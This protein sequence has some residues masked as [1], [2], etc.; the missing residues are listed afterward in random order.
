M[1]LSDREIRAALARGALRLNPIPSPAAWSSTAVDLTLNGPLSCWRTPAGKRSRIVIAPHSPDYDFASL[2]A[3]I[4]REI[5][6]GAEGHIVEPFSFLLGWT[7]ERIQ[8]PHESRIA[9]RVEGKS[10]LAR[11]GLGVHVTAPTIHAG[12]GMTGDPIYP[13][14]SIRLEVWNIGPLRIKLEKGMPICQLIFE[15]V[16]GTPEKGY[17]GRFNLQGP[18]ANP[19]PSPSG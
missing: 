3:Q 14:S 11:L 9:A 6:L 2:A 8:L 5:P 18:E 17:A 10:S 13:G 15:W 16:D 12:F 7:V 1:I 19:A 4:G